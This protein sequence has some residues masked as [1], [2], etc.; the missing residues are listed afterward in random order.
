MLTQ[1]M[2]RKF[3]SDST[4]E[5]KYKLFL[6]GTQLTQ[7]RNDFET[8]RE[9]LDTSS[10]T[11]ERKSEGLPA[12][13]EAAIEAQHKYASLEDAQNID[14]RIDAL[15]NELVWSQIIV[16]E[17][18][19]EKLKEEVDLAEQNLNQM[20]EVYE[21]QKL[22][23]EKSVKVI[24]EA[25]NE[26]EAYKNLPDDFSEEKNQLTEERVRLNA[27]LGDFREEL[28]HIN[29]VIKQTKLAKQKHERALKA[30][31][32]KLEAS[33][34]TKRDEILVQIEKLKE[35]MGEKVSKCKQF[36]IEA[37]ELFDDMK[38]E[39]QRK[40]RMHEN[41]GSLRAKLKETTNLINKLEAQRGD[42][43]R[44]YGTNIPKVLSEIRR[45]SRWTKRRPVGPMGSTLK[46]LKP[47]FSDTLELILNKSMNSFVVECFE[48]K[49]LLLSILK[50]CNCGNIPIMVADYDLF[51]YSSGEPD[52]R[53]LTVL[54]AIKFEDEWVKRQFI[55]FNKIEKILLMEDRAEADDIMLHQPKNIHLCFT[56]SGHKVGSKSGMK[57]ETLDAY[58]GPPR[59]QTDIDAEIRKHKEEQD[60]L[61]E[62]YDS[63]DR[64][65]RQIHQHIQ[66]LD[67][68]Y[69]QC[70][71]SEN[72][73]DGEIKALERYIDMEEDKL[74]EDDPVDLNMYY[75]DIKAAEEKIQN[76]VSQFQSI[77][78]QRD[79]LLKQVA[80]IEKQIEL[81][82]KKEDA[83]ESVV[84]EHQEKINKLHAFK[85]KLMGK[86]NEY[87]TQRQTAKARYEARRTAYNESLKLVDQW[88]KECITDYP[89][90][91][92]T[93]KTP[94]EIELELKKLHKQVE[95]IE[96]ELGV[97]LEE[98][99]K[100]VRETVQAWHDAEEVTKGMQR[101]NRSLRKMLDAR[102]LKWNQFRDFMS[103]SAKHYF[104]YYLH[105]RGDEGTLKFNH[106]TKKLDI[107]VSTGDQ[108]SKGSR[109]KDS[110][111]LSGG[112]KSF[113]QIS[114]LLSLWQ[115]I[116]SPIIW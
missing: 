8:I 91:V 112:E 33:T 105:L 77:N 101:L 57:T 113:S 28:V 45:E 74:K 48:D 6:H 49:N 95:S 84:I 44:A 31:T 39:K 24:E 76:Y 114:L 111:S 2:A 104:S 102:Q 90:R 75:E 37:S 94:R 87:N 10:V 65:F 54:R 17:K 72:Q 41:L 106:Q 63:L 78:A 108:Y 82:K 43:M 52:Q 103:L 38:K 115:S 23:I 93:T 7:L 26:L 59:F 100:Y 88:T 22:K 4:S 80:D 86:L 89:D 50:R 15:N 19:S 3:L 35:K 21:D 110:R 47:Q 98:Y 58:R 30:E 99:G 55:I 40:E 79:P 46:L 67:K 9:S 85:Q 62:K 116:S 32:D 70:K 27:K 109:Q 53:Y 66:D 42:R 25:N 92:D 68:R 36:G 81:L 13:R 60:S 16:K 96:A 83:R 29:T 71:N 73:I 61:Q 14:D 69:R 56:S 97:N 34:K 64:E 20:K 18:E 11:L 51:D 12:L 5:D 107:R 1:D